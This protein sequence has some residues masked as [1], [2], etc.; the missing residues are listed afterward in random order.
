MARLTF[1][2]AEVKRVV[3]HALASSAG[4][5]LVHDQGVYLMSRGDPPDL[6]KPDKPGR[7]V[8]YARGLSPADD[9]WWEKAREAVGGD[10][11][12]ESLPL[13]WV[14]AIR[15]KIERGDKTVILT[16]SKSSMKLA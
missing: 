4:M 12:A 6:L 3:D 10:D 16:L 15:T 5:L 14:K 1:K 13:D 2:A 8:A 7:Y 9:N 11:F